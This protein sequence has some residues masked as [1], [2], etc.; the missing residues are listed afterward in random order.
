MPVSPPLVLRDDDGQHFTLCISNESGA[1][2]LRI[3]SLER[4][5]ELQQKQRRDRAALSYGQ[6]AKM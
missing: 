1:D 3:V 6:E 4:H 5:G 2:T